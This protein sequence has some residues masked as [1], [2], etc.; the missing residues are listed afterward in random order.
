MSDPSEHGDLL[1]EIIRQKIMQKLQN[2]ENQELSESNKKQ[3]RDEIKEELIREGIVKKD[4]DD[5]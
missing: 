2:M 4:E 1:R 5:R 3:L